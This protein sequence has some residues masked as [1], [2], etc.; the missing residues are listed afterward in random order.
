MENKDAIGINAGIVWRMLDVVNN[1]T[2][3]DL[4]EKTGLTTIEVA[5]AIGW[6][7]RED[8]LWISLDA[9]NN[10]IYSIYKQIFY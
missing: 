3:E 7:A 9:D 6:L 10:M 4:V 1:L 5:S 8:K 2:I